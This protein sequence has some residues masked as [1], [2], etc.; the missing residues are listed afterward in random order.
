MSPLKNAECSLSPKD[1]ILF[2]FYSH[3][4][5]LGVKIGALSISYISV[6]RIMPFLV[7]QFQNRLYSFFK[8]LRAEHCSG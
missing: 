4:M 6:P 8:H 1:P 7:L 5:P 2:L 3:Q